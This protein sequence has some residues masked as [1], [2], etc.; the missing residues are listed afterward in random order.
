MDTETR[1]GHTSEKQQHFYQGGPIFPQRPFWVLQLLFLA[2]PNYIGRLSS[3]NTHLG[4]KLTGKERDGGMILR[5]PLALYVQGR[6]SL[7]APVDSPLLPSLPFSFFRYFSP[8]STIFF[9]VS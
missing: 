3:V 8:F 6:A 2:K 4:G 5:V 1:G 9:C 7:P